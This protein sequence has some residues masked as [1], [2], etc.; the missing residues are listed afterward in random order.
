[1]IH[2]RNLSGVDQGL[3]ATSKIVSGSDSVSD[4]TQFTV[5]GHSFVAI[6]HMSEDVEQC[7]ASA[8]T[9]PRLVGRIACSGRRYL[10]YDAEQEQASDPNGDPAPADILTRRELQ[11]ALLIADGK[12]DK[13][14]ARQLGI[15][16]YT[17]REHIRRTFA[18]LGIGRRS[19]IG[20][21]ILRRQGSRR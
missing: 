17:V 14:I 8:D 12:C 18:K 10:V 15:S 16:G 13:E 3:G 4:S 9:D 2:D 21:C 6:L 20:A 1:M 19:A 11:V 7:G 5:D